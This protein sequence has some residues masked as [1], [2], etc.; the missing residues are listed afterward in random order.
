MTATRPR[1]ARLSDLH[2]DLHRSCLD[3]AR[4]VR[5]DSAEH[6]RV[7]QQAASARFYFAQLRQ[8]GE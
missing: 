7:M 4:L 1:R 6:A 5:H 8:L 2:R 3:L